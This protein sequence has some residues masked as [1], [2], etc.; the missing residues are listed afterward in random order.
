MDRD[1]V[2]KILN[3]WFKAQALDT[4]NVDGRMDRWFETDDKAAEELRERFG[5]LMIRALKGELDDW[6]EDPE[7]H[8]ALILLLDQFPRKLFPSRKE[9]Y[10]GDM[11][12]LKLCEQGVLNGSYRKLTPEQQAFFF[13][14]LQRAESVR[15]Q[16]TSVKIYNSLVRNVSE[17][18]RETFRTFAQ[19]AELRRD[20]VTEF[21]RFPHRNAL[22]GRPNTEAEQMFLD[23]D[24]VSH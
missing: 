9:A 19:F 10:R 2:N 24:P 3:Y 11:K 7:A 20:I 16:E 8:L 17:T 15:I 23:V 6:A 5:G 12:A 14:P 18:M 1:D 13:M 4:P 21:G 22:L